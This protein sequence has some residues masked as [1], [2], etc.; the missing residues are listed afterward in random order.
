MIDLQELTAA[1]SDTALEPWLV[2]LPQQLDQVLNERSHGDMPRWQNALEHLPDWSCDELD[3]S[4][5]V[6]RIR[7][8]ATRTEQQ[9]AELKTLLQEFIPWRKGPFDVHGIYIDTEWHSDWKWSRIEQHISDLNGRVVLD[10]GCG[11]GY[12]G[13]R[14]ADAGAHLVVGIDPSRLF[15]LQYQVIKHF[16]K[17]RQL[18]F[19]MLPLGI[20]HMPENLQAFDTVFSMGVLYHRKSPLEHLLQL[21]SCL[22]AGGELVLETLVIDGEE[23]MTLLPE[24]RYAKMRNVWFIPSVPTLELWLQRCGYTNIRVVDVS[25]TS[26]EEQRS[27]EWMRFESL[28]D[29]F[30]P[31]DSSKTVEGYPA[32]KRAVLIA[33]A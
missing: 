17:P 7:S 29:F 16:L 32:P 20:Q 12:H 19:H 24:D 33:T 10:V 13:W 15:L 3:M 2:D 8:Q 14:M 27:T 11:S 25:I 21:K 28:P 1:L 22:R 18:P 6:I 4:D 9:L 30:D 23:G 31:Q 26:V 5:G